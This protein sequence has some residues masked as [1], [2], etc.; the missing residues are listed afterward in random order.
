MSHV[1]DMD[2]QFKSAASA[3]GNEDRIVEILRRFTV[4]GDN[5]KIAKIPPTGDVFTANFLRRRTRLLLNFCAESMWQMMLANDNLDV[6][7]HFAVAA[8]NFDHS[9]GG[10]GAAARIA[11][12]FHVHNRS[13]QFWQARP[14]AQSHGLGS[15]E[16][17]LLSQR[18]RELF[19]RRNDNF[20]SDPRFIRQNDVSMRPIAEEADHGGMRTR[21]DFLDSTLEAA[22]GMMAA[23]AREDVVTVHCVAHRMRANE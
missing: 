15:V 14:L 1:G 4:N 12:D 6:D 17:Q 21:G 7:A 9:S 5:R 19:S 22:V 16:M 18:G 3:R 2:L 11:R 20:V 23:D 13:V 8:Q 10:R